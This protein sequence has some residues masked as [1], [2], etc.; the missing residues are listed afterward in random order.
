MKVHIELTDGLSEDE[1][2]IRCGQVDEKLQKIY[3]YIME[4]SSSVSQIIFYKDNQEFYFPIDEVLFFE[5]E[6]EFLYAH[7]G[8][9]EYRIKYRLHELDDILPKHFV[10]ASKSAIVN[11]HHVYSI[12][13]NI[14]ASS[15]IQFKNS[16]KHVYV[17]RLYFNVL[18]QRLNERSIYEK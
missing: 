3:R 4:Q 18:R 10:R 17:S 15:L 14:T 2:I 13:R 8:N 9:D 16:H 6:G 1:V 12:T 7:T 5:T 11:I